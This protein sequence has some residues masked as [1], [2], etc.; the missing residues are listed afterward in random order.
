MANGS[1]GDL[2]MTLGL[3]D[4]V[5]RS[6]SKIISGLNKTD[7][8]ARQVG[9]TLIRDLNNA[10]NVDLSKTYKAALSYIEQYDKKVGKTNESILKSANK[11][12]LALQGLNVGN[13]FNKK[14]F[15]SV[16]ADF[17]KLIERLKVARNA[18]SKMMD[19]DPEKATPWNTAINN[20]LEYIKILQRVKYLEEDVNTTKKSN[21]N[22]DTKALDA[23]LKKVQD[24]R[25]A[26]YRIFTDSG[27]DGTS[28]IG[29]MNKLFSMLRT[30]IT[31][32]NAAFKKENPLSVFEGGAAK[33]KA[34]IS[35]V[36]EKLATLRDMITEGQKKGYN[37]SMLTG[38]YRELEGLLNRLNNTKGNGS[39]LTDTTHMKSLFSDLSV[40]IRETQNA[41]HAY[42]REKGKAIAANKEAD[43]QKRK[44][45]AEINATRTLIDLQ[46][47]LNHTANMAEKGVLSKGLGLGADTTNLSVKIGE[48]RSF[49]NSLNSVNPA[50]M[51]V[52]SNKAFADYKSDAKSLT[53]ALQ[54]AA[55]AQKELNSAKNAANKE[56]K[57]A[58][59]KADAQAKRDAAKAAN[60]YKAALKQLD[61]EIEQA[62]QRIQSMEKAL[63]NLQEKRFTSK[64][65][66]LDT[67]EADAK[68]AHMKNQLA[69]LR[70]ILNGLNTRGVKAIGQIG[71]IGNG[72]E[73][74]AA[75]NLASA[76]DKANKE[77]ERGERL[78]EQR[79][80]KIA[81]S[82]SK[83]RN[84]LANAFGKANEEAGKMSSALSDIKSLFLQGGIVFGAKQFFDSIVQTG[85]EIV[86][87]HVALRSILGD[88]Q[89]ADELFAQTQQ[90]ALQSPFKFGELNRDVKQ[91]AAF[92]VEANDLYDTT[93]RLADIA[94][95]LGVSFERLGLAYGQVKARSWL[96][97]KELRQFAYAG[98]PLLQ[99][100]AELYNSTG[101]NGKT[102]YKAGDIKKMISAR[103]VSFEDVQK[104]LWQMTD[105][106]GQFYNMQL[107]L[108]DTLLG[109]WN[110]LID[111]W[112]IMTG[113]MAEGKSIV[114]GTFSFFINRVT[115]LVLALDKMQPA[116]LAFGAMFALKKG[117]S[118]VGSKIGIGTNLAALQAEQQTLLRTYAVEQQKLLIE[119][120]IT[121]QKMQQNIADYQGFLNSKMNTRNAVEQEAL[122][123]RLS[124]LKLQKAYAEKL[125]FPELVKQLELM[126]VISAKQSELI[127]KS[128]NWAKAQLAAQGAMSKIGGFFSGWNIATIGVTIAGALYSAWSSFNSKIKQDTETTANNAKSTYE[129]MANTLKEIG[130]KKGT[131]EALQEQVDKMTETLKQSNLY[132]DSIKEQIANTNDLG[133]EYDILKGKIEEVAKANNFTPGEAN[134]YARAK[135][136]TGAGF[137]GGGSWFGQWTGIGQ[138]NIDENTDDVANTLASLQMKM[139]KFGNTTKKTMETVADSILGAKA[140]GMTFE[141][142]MA[143]IYSQN[144]TNGYWDTFVKKVSG[145]RKDIEEDL[146]GLEDDLGGF[147]SNFKE[148]TTDDIPKYLEEMAKSRNMSLNEFSQWCKKHPEKFGKML[149]EMLSEANSKV[150]NLVAR[151][152][153]VAKA[154]LNIGNTEP[155]KQ[156]NKPKVWKNPLKEG[157]IDRK[158]FN[159]LLDAGKLSGG[160]GGFYQK[161][162]AAL[163]YGLNNGQS[164]GWEN[165]GSAVQKAYKEARNE[166]DA[167]KAAGEKVPHA[168]KQAMLEAIANQLGITL[169]IGKN[170][171]TGNYGKG[172]RTGR[173]EDKELKALEERLSSYKSAR[174]SYQKRQSYMSD[175]AAKE[176]TYKLF[177][178]VTGLNLDNY[179]SA[180]KS[181]LNGFKINTTERKKFQT[182][183]YREV[184]DWLFEEGDK[185]EFEKKAATFSEEMNRLSDR[186]DLYKSLLEK[187]GNKDYASAAFTTTDFLEDEKTQKLMDL[188]E[189][190]YH[191]RLENEDLYLTEGQA[192]EQ[193]KLP[194]QYEEWKKIV[195]LLRGNY[196]QALNDGADAINQTMSTAKKL[197]AITA[198]YSKKRKDAGDNDDLKARYDYL[199][200]Q[201][202]SSV[203][204]DQLKSQV[205]WDGVFG[206]LGNYTKKELRKVRKDLNNLVNGGLLNGMQ[207]SD[208]QSFYDGMNKLNEAID[209][210][211]F[212]GMAELVKELADAS[213]Q[214]DNAVEEYNKALAG[215]A[216]WQIEAAKKKMQAAENQKHT[217]E[218]N[219]KTKKDSD[220]D[221]IM[222][223]GNMFVTL[224]KGDG[225]GST[226]LSNAGSW[227]QTISSMFGASDKNS[228]KIGAIV[229]MFAGITEAIH[230]KGA[231][232]FL[233]N[234]FEDIGGAT[235][236]IHNSKGL[237]TILNPFGRGA[238]AIFG[239]KTLISKILNPT[240]LL[241]TADYDDYNDAKEE[242]NNLID[243]WDT[244]ISKKKQYMSEHWGTE[245]ANASKEALSLLQSE[246]E[247]TKELAKIR[248]SSGSSL[249]SHAIWY[250][251]WKGSYDYNGTNWQDVAGEISSEYGV[252]FN[253]MEDM[254]NMAPDV[255][256]KIKT[257]YSG[258][259]AHMDSDFK[260]YLDK[261]IEYGDQ[262][263]DMTESLT[264][265]LTGNKFSDLVS[266]W[267]DA[268]ATMANSSDNL[269]DHF[270]DNLKKTILNSMVENIYGKQIKSLLS[271]TQSY[272]ENS[273]KITSSNGSTVSE[274]TGEEYAE[275]INDT[276]ELSKQIEATRDYL[277]N[278]Y[279]WSDDSSSS[280]TNTVKGITE[281]TADIIVSYL[282]AIR[283]DVSVNRENVKLIADAVNDI[284][285][286]TI[287]ARSQLTQLDSIA[288]NTL[289]N[290]DAAE[291]IVSL[292]KAVTNGTKKVY[293]N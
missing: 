97:G 181:L 156:D 15:D 218:G 100:I 35:T 162:M 108:S 105:Q 195:D 180:V 177:P 24:F 140:A 254:L 287:I 90:L 209:G 76:Y 268:M 6:L 83:A 96:D 33:V 283:L 69:D 82:A 183:V 43:E 50:T 291:E 113:K 201:E 190:H 217:A 4:E 63:A 192:K 114:G 28:V 161:E 175:E 73:V 235:R 261:I 260:E 163:I 78:E 250:R 127:V 237:G 52:G 225:S 215:G 158:A 151:L 264:E 51:G 275:I 245:A 173:Q 85:G 144:G 5:T 182:S 122:E 203:L 229:G 200:K 199:E 247:Q 202:K 118:A 74:Q 59:D 71:S 230:E 91:L 271:K 37:F 258:L 34:E 293:M 221:N 240:D 239:K 196:V 276:E 135:A 171:V 253:S 98:L 262:V 267:G 107:V 292:F 136:A 290:A 17:G 233:S 146:E 30:E 211:S 13:L 80:Q 269:I 241:T 7:A 109:R 214:Y 42:G 95:G 137:A 248:L 20:A 93:K 259:W 116:L 155:K 236:S 1:M 165:F 274:Y 273:D 19:K 32:T 251:M 231:D 207:T 26:L 147:G 130:D 152:Q 208:V 75:N 106:G 128:G 23:S 16:D 8:A 66:G 270:E 194:N 38:Q 133:K 46:N 27:V 285:D 57:R 228:S 242:Y 92:G 120:K 174:Q 143:E 212:G 49:I 55:Q 142:K 150:P 48:L 277:K 25:S 31:K 117:A 193:Y 257:D 227:A 210:K 148:I 226:L 159:K 11:A 280:S 213:K 87:Q 81:E 266:S 288:Q 219:I 112:D 21:P 88:V 62:K 126:G 45:E 119:G 278:T 65:L 115:D 64:M 157:T 282:N 110:K 222:T 216:D 204:F 61:R 72:R 154:I 138:D 47:Q 281:E 41:M 164:T 79:A 223:L 249:G 134:A 9:A 187:T 86:Q 36:T 263:D 70:D 206:N 168:R 2:F 178:E 286:L 185:K 189:Q 272:A 10:Q 234:A 160:K 220:F 125:I 14:G 124:A 167:A 166:N 103:E 141:E 244:L 252:Q 179:E 68:I 198:K 176:E 104:V 44:L 256:E 172:G 279:H 191:K 169:D 18:I 101:K 54:E 205:N 29:D 129:S 102:D 84:D 39:L 22:V 58:Q 224:G 232:R 238:S 94:S 111:A 40:A 123:G 121:Q 284:P 255:L 77:V 149:D 3:K 53:Y 197:D 170:K 12:L 265:K 145:G 99:K 56:A 246:I 132:T 139:E 243:V 67:T 184:A 131:G 60:E 186:W 289:R 188:Y 153:Q 89:K